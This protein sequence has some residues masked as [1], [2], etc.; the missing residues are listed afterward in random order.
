MEQYVGSDGVLYGVLQ[1]ALYGCVQ[2]SKLWYLKLSQFLRNA[3]YENS[4]MEPCVFRK[5]EENQVF[6]LIV[7]VDD[8]LIIAS[9]NEINRLHSLCIDEFRW[10][11]L[12]MGNVHS[13]LGMQLEFADGQVRVN[14]SNYVDKGLA[15]Y[16][17]VAEDRRVPGR[18]GVFLVAQNSAEVGVNERQLFHTIVAKLLYLAKRA[19]PDILAVV[20]FLCTRVK[21]PTLEDVEK[22]EY[23]LGY[24][25]RTRKLLMVLRPNQ[26]LKVEAYVDASF[27]HGWE[28]TF[29][30]E[31][32]SGWCRRALHIMEAEV[33]Q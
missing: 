10:V 4:E 16:P 25:C 29:W 14:M 22:L 31:D 7:Y 9:E 3:G 2:A 13:Y 30:G 23:L 6:L 27:A 28:I 32:S 18:K 12:E 24:L 21:A 1:K 15:A 33:C 17:K 20:G 11:T 26:S 5:V 19:R 8:I